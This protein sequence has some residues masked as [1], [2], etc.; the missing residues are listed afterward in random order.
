MDHTAGQDGKEVRRHLR[1]ILHWR[2]NSTRG[3][4]HQER[5]TLD[6]AQTLIVNL[7]NNADLRN[8]K[9]RITVKNFPGF[10]AQEFEACDKQRNRTHPF[11]CMHHDSGADPN[12]IGQ[13]PP[14]ALRSLSPELI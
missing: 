10:G 13:V 3:G 12:L 11:A 4:R 14:L 8:V 1:R 2:R 9:G 7:T 5:F 6:L